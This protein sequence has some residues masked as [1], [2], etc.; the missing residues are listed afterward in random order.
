MVWALPT[1]AAAASA[2][3]IQIR[4]RV[5]MCSVPA[6]PTA[7]SPTW[8]DTGSASATASPSEGKSEGRGEG[9]ED[10]LWR[11]AARRGVGVG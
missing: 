8:N 4:R 3:A 1:G 5:V 7:S 10:V 2:D 6:W 11:G 9:C